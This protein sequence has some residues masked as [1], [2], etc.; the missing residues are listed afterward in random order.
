MQLQQ[1]A[2]A[3]TGIATSRQ[4]QPLPN[5]D[6]L[7][8]T[9]NMIPPHDSPQPAQFTWQQRFEQLAQ[10]VAVP[11]NKLAV[12]RGCEPFVPTPMEEE[13]AM[14]ARIIKSFSYSASHPS[15]HLIC[16]KLTRSA[17]ATPT[18]NNDASPHIVTIPP[19]AFASAVGIVVFTTGRLGLSQ[20]SGSTGSGILITRR[21]QQEQTTPTSNASAWNHPIAIQTH[22]VGYGP[23]AFGFDV[24]DRVYLI[25]SRE[26]LEKLFNRGQ[27]MVGPEVVLAAM[28]WGGGAGLTFSGS[29]Q[30]VHRSVKVASQRWS[31]SRR[32]GQNQVQ[33]THQDVP[34]FEPYH[35]EEKNDHEKPWEATGTIDEK[36]TPP[37][38]NPAP[39]PSAP[40]NTQAQA[41][42]NTPSHPE[43]TYP[44]IHCYMRSRGFYAG[45]QAE[46]TAF[47]ERAETNAEF[48]GRASTT[49]VTPE[50]EK[51]AQTSSYERR[52]YESA[53]WR[54]ASLGD[55][56][57]WRNGPEV[58]AV[59]GVW[60]ALREAEFGY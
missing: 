53:G 51:G 7:N 22:G 8:A 57:S 16:P 36:A 50:S 48:Y 56:P 49:N 60:E 18:D 13:C 1:Q 54:N 55:D 20:L 26:T 14:A 42:A 38:E 3:E 24:S 37:M 33:P 31:Q 4:A 15:E 10:R 59:E 32:L 41:P 11:L 21:L 30:E 39:A 52:D 34:K 12:K 25:R 44:P 45:L 58:K 17:D 2:P 29:L 5:K 9:T 6:S 28:K 19:S 27:F 35:D 46:G 40:A 43:S 23:L 47:S